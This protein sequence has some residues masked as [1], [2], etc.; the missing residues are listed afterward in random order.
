MNPGIKNEVSVIVTEER[1]AAAMGS[2]TLP[3]FATPSMVA[4]MEQTAAESVEALL[5]EGNTTVGTMIHVNHLAA[6]PLGMKVTCKSELIAVEGRKLV[7]TIE[8]SD[9]AGV[10]GTAEHERFV[11]GAARFLEKVNGKIKK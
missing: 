6:T 9:E 10:I 5:E 11:V 7:F 2:G 4:L 3:V 8:A 1:T